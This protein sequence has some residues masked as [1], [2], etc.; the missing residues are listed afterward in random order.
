M[1]T[2]TVVREQAPPSDR[3]RVPQPAPV[4]R[5]THR[6]WR[7][8]PGRGDTTPDAAQAAR[9]RRVIHRILH[10]DKWR[11]H[12]K[13]LPHYDPEYVYDEGHEY[14]DDWTTDPDY[15][16]D[17]NHLHWR[18]F[19]EEGFLMPVPRDHAY[20]IGNVQEA[21]CG[22]LDTGHDT[23]LNE[24]DY[25]FPEELGRV[26]GLRTESGA[27]QTKVQPDVVVLP[28]GWHDGRLPKSRVLRVDAD[29]PVPTLVVEVVSASTAGR[30]REGKRALYE[31]LGVRE[32][33]LLD[34]G[35]EDQSRPPGLVLYRLQDGVYARVPGGDPGP[36]AEGGALVLTPVFSEV[37][38]T[39]LRLVRPA[40]G[41]RLVCQWRDP[42]TGR[43]RDH[44]TDQA[45][46]LLE[47]RVE[48]RV[49]AL[50]QLLERILPE[51]AYPGAAAQ[52]AQHWS[53]HGLPTDAEARVLAAAAESDRW[54]DHLGVPAGT[55]RT[56]PFR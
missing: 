52:V 51:A 4:P 22:A 41:A 25:H 11:A 55:D 29:H 17:G 31:A 7:V 9:R 18:I 23:V 54:R 21:L 19:D 20:L 8:P 33:L 38:D 10:P 34:P 14:E 15:C 24:P 47:S 39:A 45:T 46:A 42:G 1:T 37:C 40:S 5:W 2:N 48:G 26:A 53:A 43:W 12:L 50:L 44:D 28:P 35:G 56:P 49:E 16:W 6:D 13:S 27:I 30:D 32:Y 3:A 36:S